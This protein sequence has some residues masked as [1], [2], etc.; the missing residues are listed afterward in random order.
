MQVKYIKCL[1]FD[2]ILLRNGRGHGHVTH[3]KKVCPNYIFRI[4]EARHFIF[5]VLID[6]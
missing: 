1:A 5:C 4:G 2:D 6:T 3:V